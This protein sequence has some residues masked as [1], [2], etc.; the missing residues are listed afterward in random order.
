MPVVRKFNVGQYIGIVYLADH[1]KTTRY[2]NGYVI[3]PKGHPSEGK[4]YDDIKIDVHGG[5]TF[6]ERLNKKDAHWLPADL[7]EEADGRSMYGFDCAHLNDS[8]NFNGIPHS[9]NE[10]Y[11]TADEVEAEVRSMIKQFQRKRHPRRKA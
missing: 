4:N 6:G 3:L 9:D 10:H 1:M 5:L 2:H 8:T 11:W 7:V